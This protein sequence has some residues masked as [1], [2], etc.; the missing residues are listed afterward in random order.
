MALSDDGASG[1]DIGDSLA[2]QA[3]GEVREV[4]EAISI[5]LQRMS[6]KPAF[7][8]LFRVANLHGVLQV[9]TCS[10]VVQ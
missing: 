9:P 10:S 6:A 5:L 7:H 3:G 2:P 4:R 1:K 8:K